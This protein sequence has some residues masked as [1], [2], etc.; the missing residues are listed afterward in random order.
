MNFSPGF[1]WKKN[2][3]REKKK[4]VCVQYMCECVC[5]CVCAPLSLL[6]YL[7]FQPINIFDTYHV[8]SSVLASVNKQEWDTVPDFQELTV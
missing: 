5:V 4:R 6:R 2:N 3:T 7:F 1:L 8:Q